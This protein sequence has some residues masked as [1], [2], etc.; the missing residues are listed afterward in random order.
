MHLAQAVLVWG[1]AVMNG[2]RARQPPEIGM[3]SKQI[4]LMPNSMAALGHLTRPDQLV[5]FS[6]ARGF[7]GNAIGRRAAAL[8]LLG[9]YAVF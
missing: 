6:E 8:N 2:M 3:N 1:T 9:N 5:G 7:A 4:V